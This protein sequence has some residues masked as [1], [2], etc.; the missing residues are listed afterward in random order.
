MAQPST[1]EQYLLELI[2]AERAKVGAQPLAFDGDLNEASEDHSQWMI[3]TDT[4]SHTGSGGSTAGQRMTAAGYAFTGSWS[5]GENIAWATTR[6]P[7][8]LQDE[9]L[10]LHTNLMN[11]SGHRAN[12]LNANYREVGLGFEVGD[13]GGRDSAFITEDFARSGSSVYLTGVAF[14]DKDGDRF[15]DVGEEL[16]GLTLTAVSSTGATYTTTT[17]GSGG[18]DLALPPASYTVTFSGAGIQTTSMQTTIGSKNV[19]LD[20]IDPAT[21]GGSQPPPSEP[22]PPASNVIAGTASGETLSG[23]AGADTIQG[24]GGDDR[25]YGQSGNDRLEGGSGRDYLY[26]S[27]G[28]DTLIGGNGNDRL[29]GGAGRDVLTG[30]ANQDSFVFDTSL[31]AWNIDKITDFST[32]DDTIRLDNAIFKAFGWNGTMPSSAF[33]TGAAAHDS[34]DRIIYNSDTGALS[35]DPDGT[36]SAAAVQFAELSTKLALTS[37]DFLII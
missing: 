15:Y 31:G 24:L 10:L 18:Y 30:G 25:L 33:Y 21:S 23:T 8:G 27:T 22:P 4:F 17:Y 34:T 3:G 32:V 9:V 13:Y 29:Y 11:S 1:Y 35:Y 36:G 6:S 7:A 5:W 16:G 19:K 20:L 28:D 14:D 26:G 2:N 12:I 37:Y